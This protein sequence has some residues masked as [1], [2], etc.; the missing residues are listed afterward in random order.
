[1]QRQKRLLKKA[2]NERDA[3][4]KEKLSLRKE[5]N[6]AEEILASVRQL[7][8]E[9]NKNESKDELAWAKTLDQFK[10]VDRKKS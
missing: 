4:V 2:Q 6:K 9:D 3:A 10:K 7:E 5:L 8:H 1:M